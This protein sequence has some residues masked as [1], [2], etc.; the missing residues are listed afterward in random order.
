MNTKKLIALLLSV[1]FVLALFAGC[2][3][4]ADSDDGEATAAPTESAAA[5]TES[6]DAPT[7]SAD[8]TQEPARPG[9]IELPLVTEYT[10][11]DLF[12]GMMPPAMEYIESMEECLA[13]QTLEERTGIHI[14][15]TVVHPSVQADSF[16]LMVST[17]DYA[18]FLDMVNSLYAG[19]LAAAIEQDVILDLS[20]YIDEYCPNYSALINS[21]EAVHRDVTLDDGSIGAFYSIYEEAEYIDQG[22]MV[23]SDWLDALGMEVPS[24][25]DEYH[26]FIQA[27]NSEYGAT[28]WLPASG[29]YTANNFISGFGIAGGYTIGMS[30][31]LQCFYVEDGKVK[32]GWFEDG[33]KDYLSLMNQWYSEGLIDQDYI[34]GDSSSMTVNNQELAL[35]NLMTDKYSV[36]GDEIV[37]M[38]TY[39]MSYDGGSFP[40]VP[41]YIPTKNEGDTI[42]VGYY[43]SRINRASYSVSTDCEDIELALK[44]ID[45]G[46][47]EEGSLLGNW[48]IE[49]KTFDVNADGSKY[50]T[51]LILN[52]P[53]GMPSNVAK[54]VYLRDSGPY[55]YDR[56]RDMVTYSETQLSCYDVWPSN[57]DMANTIP[58][59]LTLNTDESDT[60]GRLS[61]DIFTFV[62]ESI[63]KYITGATSM[64]EYDTFVSTLTDLGMNDIVA[65]YQAAYDRYIAK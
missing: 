35:S 54:F 51:D 55:V 16:N 53:D 49:G 29:I 15:I 47:T 24:T 56:A 33:F 30:T 43:T 42:H 6:A 57:Y 59:T 21:D 61:G 13:F 2:G 3:G 22:V 39:N 12:T 10:E 50:L 40:A 63:N 62:S 32:C 64:D 23:R 31:E 5:P 46:Y 28:M 14:N 25:Y 18:D 52:N 8:A 27:A 37:A 26:D 36:W 44:W 4:D 41:S 34:S 1:V 20:Q 7:D 38:D 65:L 58:N 9:D 60:Y 45:Y 11:F 48:G 17:G 19:G